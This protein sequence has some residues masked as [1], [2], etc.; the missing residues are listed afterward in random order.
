[1]RWQHPGR[2]LLQ[3]GDFLE[4]AEDSGII[5]GIGRQ[6]LDEV[7]ALLA[8]DPGLPGAVNVNFSAVELSARG[9]LE[10][11]VDT[12][13]RYGVDPRRLVV[14]VTE[15]A[16]LSL[17]DGT[18]SDLVALRALGVGVQ[19]DDFGTGFSSISLLR[20]LPVTGIKL[21]RSFVRD[22]TED[23]SPANALAAG[24]AGLAQGLHLAGI[25]EGIETEAQ[26]RVLVEQG[27]VH[28]QGY[29]FGRPEAVPRGSS[30][31]DAWL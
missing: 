24:V 10:H 18:H 7:C 25:A 2:G 11:V 19:V 27:W 13:T 12:I 5:V 29:L 31:V 23:D 17:L 4:V 9:W 1:M 30:I 22:L 21:D 14:E 20:D 15:T 28:G 16:V 3:P 6:L 26:R 8:A